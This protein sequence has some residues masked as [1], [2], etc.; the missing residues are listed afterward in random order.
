M[1][2][3]TKYRFV[4]DEVDGVLGVESQI[5]ASILVGCLFELLRTGGYQ[6]FMRRLWA[7]FRGGL[8]SGHAYSD[9]S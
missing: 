8:P 9:A 6:A 7:L 1:T 4:E 3:G 2:L 5:P